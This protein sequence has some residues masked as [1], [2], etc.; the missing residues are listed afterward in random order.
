MLVPSPFELAG[1]LRRLRGLGS[2]RLL[3]RLDLLG[4]LI[5]LHIQIFGHNLVTW[6][7]NHRH[8]LRLL[9]L[10][11]GVGCGGRTGSLRSGGAGGGVRLRGSRDAIRRGNRAVLSVG[12]I[13]VEG[14]SGCACRHQG[15]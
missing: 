8:I 10:A 1:W 13:V 9:R 11:D 5:F 7:E 6:G 4:F 12:L 3:W 14:E 2:L 15:N